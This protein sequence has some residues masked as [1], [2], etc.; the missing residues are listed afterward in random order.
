MRKLRAI[1]CAVLV[2]AL[3]MSSVAALA[4]TNYETCLNPA[5]TADLKMTLTNLD[6]D[7]TLKPGMPQIKMTVNLDR[8]SVV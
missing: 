3:L 7:G 8:K 6:L 1:L 2:V 5:S 4:A